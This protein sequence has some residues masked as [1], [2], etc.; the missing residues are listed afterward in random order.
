MKYEIIILFYLFFSIFSDAN[1]QLSFDVFLSGEIKF[2]LD[3]F[4]QKKNNFNTNNIFYSGSIEDIE[5]ILFYKHTYL[6][7]DKNIYKNHPLI[8]ILNKE[9]ILF[10]KHFPTETKFIIPKEYEKELKNDYQNYNLFIL[11]DDTYDFSFYVDFYNQEKNF[12]V[13]I[14]KKIDS[15]MKK[16]LYLVLF[17]NTIICLINSIILRKALKK[18]EPENI[19]PIH[20]LIC[21]S[22]EILFISNVINDLSFL[23]FKNK[24]YYFI[25]ENMTLFLYSF[26]KSIFYTTIILIL[27]GWSIITFFDGREKFKDLSKKIFYYDLF[28]SIAIFISIYFIYFTTKLNLIYIKN[29]SEH[30]FLLFFTISCIFK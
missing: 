24:E 17:L 21:S 3:L 26:Y 5:E 29:I 10:I 11:K 12:Y 18:V 4:N 22:S 14:G 19:L 7:L 16:N 8:Y 25:S 2:D 9:Y 13:K 28:F 20:Y 6:D 30:F 15:T 27:K 1:Y 23:I